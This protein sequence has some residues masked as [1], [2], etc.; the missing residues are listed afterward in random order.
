MESPASFTNQYVTKKRVE[1]LRELIPEPQKIIFGQYEGYLQENGVDHHS[2]T[3]TFFA[4]RTHIDSDRFHGVPIYVR[5]GKK[6]AQ[7]VTEVSVVFNVA[8][9]RLF[10]HIEGGGAPNILIYR[11]QPNEG[12][13]L[14]FLSKTPG[15]NLKLQNEYM[16]YCYRQSS[17]S[18]ADP[19]LRL[20]VDVFR[21]DQTFFIDAPEVEAQWQFTDLLM[22]QKTTPH[23]YQRGSWGPT[24][25]DQLIQADGRNWLEPSADFCSR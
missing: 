24:E 10:A 22:A 23:I 15:P 8:G 6:L 3:D 12:I 5:A 19:Y 17:Q 14:R 9:K 2:T 7:T 11:I 16:Q 20:L 13:V 25:A 1:L 18:I 21:G 4:F